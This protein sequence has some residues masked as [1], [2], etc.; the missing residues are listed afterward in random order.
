MILL[1][2]KLKQMRKLIDIPND[3]KDKLE[4]IV[5]KSDSPDLKNFIQDILNEIVELESNVSSTAS[6]NAMILKA[7][8][9]GDKIT[10]LDALNRFDCFRLG[11]RIYNLKKLG[12][13]IT[14][15]MIKTRSGK[16]VA[17]YSLEN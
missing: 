9:N 10:P 1:I 16:H 4:L 14:K 7:L 6:Q 3:T 17:L 8:Q 11:A 2:Y 12:Y 13:P 15:E 5:D